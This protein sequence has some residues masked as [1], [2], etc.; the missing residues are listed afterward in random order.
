MSRLHR[1]RPLAVS[2]AAAALAACSS[3][4][5]PWLT[6]PSQEEH[7]QKYFPFGGGSTHTS[8]TCNDCHG[9]TAS[10]A[11]F[12]SF[13]KFDCIGCHTTP[14]SSA[15]ALAGVGSHVASACPPGATPSSTA[16]CFPPVESLATMADRIA[17]SVTC[18]GCHATGT[19]VDRAAHTSQ[20][21]PIDQGSKHFTEAC[22][23]CH[24][25][26]TRT[27]FDCIAC[28]RTPPRDAALLSG[29]GGSAH[30]VIP[31]AAGDVAVPARACFPP[32]VPALPTPADTIAWSPKCR[33]CH[34][35]GLA[36]V[37][38]S[39]HGRHFPVAGG[40]H[41]TVRCDACHSAAAFTTFD[42]VT[43]HREREPNLQSKG[44][45]HRCGTKCD[46]F[47]GVYNN[48]SATLAQ[49]VSVSPI[50]KDCHPSG[51]GGD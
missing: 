21:F 17:W 36:G 38:R 20:Y 48:P 16:P 12:D 45:G 33:L 5:S 26:G 28:H 31:C 24:T 1:L 13:R 2:L 14:P 42:C 22:S 9:D 30:A 7:A 41:G 8:V 23:G 25:Q 29:D 35:D 18:Y 32:N 40:N 39:T 6:M 15:T 50:C 37:T 49:K 10:A 11:D 4:S 27:S 47:F 44:D 3:G 34:P 46:T 43:C 19:G 51:V